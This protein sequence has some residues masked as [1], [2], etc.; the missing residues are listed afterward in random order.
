[1]IVAAAHNKWTSR[2]E[3]KGFSLPTK[4]G[5][6]FEGGDDRP[7]GLIGFKRVH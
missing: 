7:A 5:K 4:A 3:E 6:T 1:M 2:F